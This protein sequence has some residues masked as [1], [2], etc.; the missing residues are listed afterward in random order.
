M[1]AKVNEMLDAGI[2]CSIHPRD[3]RFVAQTVLAQK[4][5]EGDGLALDELKH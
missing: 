5:H 2:I 1:E 4:M 3:I